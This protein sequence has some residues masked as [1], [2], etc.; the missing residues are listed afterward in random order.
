MD[1]R[2]GRTVAFPSQRWEAW[3]RIVQAP[4]SN[5]SFRFCSHSLPVVVG[6]GFGSWSSPRLRNMAATASGFSTLATT[7]SLPLHCMPGHHVDVED[8]TEERCPVEPVSFVFFRFGLSFGEHIE[9]AS[10]LFCLDIQG[11]CRRGD[12][13]LPLIRRTKM[14][15]LENPMHPGEVLQEL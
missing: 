14:S 15:L 4:K 7:R 6:S 10:N 11:T 2:C 13:G 5:A 9:D 1:T 3:S 8:S 12:R